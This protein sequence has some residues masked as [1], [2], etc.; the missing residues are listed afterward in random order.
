MD[1]RRAETAD[2]FQ[3]L[4]QNSELKK[5][6]PPR[7]KD[8]KTRIGEIRQQSKFVTSCLGDLVVSLFSV[9]TQALN[10]GRMFRCAH[11]LNGPERLSIAEGTLNVGSISTNKVGVQPTSLDRSGLFTSL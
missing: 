7:L 10:L 6:K 4:C 2:A 9:P 5:I 11:Q 8:T 3:R 1:V